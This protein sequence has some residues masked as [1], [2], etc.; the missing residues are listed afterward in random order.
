M[1]RGIWVTGFCAGRDFAPSTEGRGLIGVTPEQLA[2]HANATKEKFVDGYAP[3]CKHL[4]LPNWTRSPIAAVRITR[5][6]QRLLRSGYVARTPEER[7][8]LERW[9]EGLTP[10]R[11]RYLDVILYHRDQLAAEGDD[12]MDKGEWGIIKVIGMRHPT[13][14]PMLPI[15]VMRNA[16]GI[17]EGGSGVALDHDAYSRSVDFWS[18]HAYAR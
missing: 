6:N 1:T 15:T 8:V 3:F 4:F 12:V 18:R 5:C 2:A 14:Q 7:P 10:L 16:L 11:A 9:F 17:A 13:E